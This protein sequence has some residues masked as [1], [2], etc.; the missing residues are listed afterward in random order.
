MSA[1]L[2][3]YKGH[4]TIELS[5]AGEDRGFTFGLKKARAI[6]DNLDAI[7]AFVDKHDKSQ[8]N[9][10]HQTLPAVGSIKTLLASVPGNGRPWPEA[11]PV[12]IVC[13]NSEPLSEDSLR[14]EA[15]C[16][17]CGQDKAGQGLLVCWNC[18]KRHP[19]SPLK[20]S[21]LSVADWLKN[22]ARF[23]GKGGS[24]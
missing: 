22:F 17:G 21:G 24:L 16:R 20:D 12:Q 13:R 19:Q 6:L 10:F 11:V 14:A 2:G 7:R 8:S 9:G 5:M 23:D 18:F 1:V 3:N 4:P 15:Y